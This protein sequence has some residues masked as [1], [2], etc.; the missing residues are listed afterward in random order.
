MKTQNLK[1]NATEMAWKRSAQDAATAAVEIGVLI[2]NATEM[3]WKR[4][5]Q[6]AATAAVEIGVLMAD[7]IGIRKNEPSDYLQYLWARSRALQASHRAFFTIPGGDSLWAVASGQAAGNRVVVVG[8]GPNPHHL[9]KG[10]GRPFVALWLG[11]S[12]PPVFSDGDAFVLVAHSVQELVDLSLIATAMA[13]TLLI[14]GLVY[15]H[16]ADLTPDLE[17]VQWPTTQWAM[18]F[19]G[20]PQ[21]VIQTP[22]QPSGMCF[23]K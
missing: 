7:A 11:T 20:S 1:H 23:K 13:E 16:V 17:P 18:Q 22:I 8:S 9:P 10:V 15:L 21:D 14:P 12:E 6:D 2:H 3:A 5:A 19:L 4:S